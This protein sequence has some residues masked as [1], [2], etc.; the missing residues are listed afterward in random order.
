MI[1]IAQDYGKV[2]ALAARIV[3]L[4]SYAEDEVL[5]DAIAAGAKGY[6]LRQVGGNNLARALLSVSSMKI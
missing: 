6:I 1:S 5:L 3:I 4:T 2:N